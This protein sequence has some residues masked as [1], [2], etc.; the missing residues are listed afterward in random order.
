[1]RRRAFLA[2]LPKAELHRHLEGAVPWAFA[3]ARNPEPPAP[4]WWEAGFVV[5]PVLRTLDSVAQTV[6]AIVR[7]KQAKTPLTSELCP[8][9]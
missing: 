5:M 3:R 7:M 6:Y 2:A 1:M 9:C 8:N 4:P